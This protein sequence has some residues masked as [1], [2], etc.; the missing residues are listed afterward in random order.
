MPR[1]LLTHPVHEVGLSALTSAGL[2]I[3]VSP[4]PDRETILSLLPKM[5]ALMVRTAGV[6]DGELMDHGPNLKVIGRHGV[7]VDHID[8]DAARE[9]GITVVNAPEANSMAV[10]EYAAGLMVSL[11]RFLPEAD[12]AARAHEWTARDRLIGTELFG[13]TVGIVGLGRV[14]SRI[15][16]ICRLGFQMRVIYYDIDRKYDIEDELGIEF[17]SFDEVIS[18]ADILTLHTPLT[19]LTHS[20]M[21]E[22]TLGRMKEGTW[23]LNTS[24]GRVVDLDALVATL[25]RGHLAGAA[26]DVFPEEPVP[27]DHPILT[28]S[29]VRLSPHMASRS[30][31]SMVRMSLVAEDIV[32]VLKGETPRFPVT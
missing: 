14:G 28:M 9:R 7:G 27:A 6:Y 32:R 16:R 26:L 8:I 1:V 10:A 2:A 5:D 29:N 13:R 11:L 21:N 3:T 22:E 20:M 12:Q 15:A 24:R 4:S 17:V 31:E 18:Q 19:P 23:L 25:N 30:A